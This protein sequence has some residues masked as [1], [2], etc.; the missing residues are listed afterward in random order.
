[1]VPGAWKKFFARSAL[2]IGDLAG[3]M[4]FQQI[5]LKKSL[6]AQIFMVRSGCFALLFRCAA[7]LALLSR[8]GFSERNFEKGIRIW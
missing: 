5:F 6:T 7:G 3:F 4:Q 1:V 8:P 2:T